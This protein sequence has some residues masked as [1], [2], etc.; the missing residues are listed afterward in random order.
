M[1]APAAARWQGQNLARNLAQQLARHLAQHAPGQKLYHL[2]CAADLSRG[3]RAAAI[4]LVLKPPPPL[5][6]I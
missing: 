1:A 3:S 4:F 6:N 5:V 2:A